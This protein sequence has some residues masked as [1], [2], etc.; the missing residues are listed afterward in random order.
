[1]KMIANLTDKLIREGQ[2]P[3]NERDIFLYGFDITLY[4]LWST[5]VLLLIGLLLGDFAGSLII[6]A[7]FY[8][9]QTF[10]GG[11]HA[12]T[13]LKCLLT[14]IVGLLVGLSFAFF[15]EQHFVL[16]TLL[17]IGALLLLLFPLV[18][19]P[20]KAYL[21]IERKRLTMHSMIV[22]ISV[23]VIVTFINVFWNGF[24]Y[25]FSAVFLLSGI[26]RIA[27]KIAYRNSYPTEDEG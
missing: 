7:A 27:G 24:L 12:R 13:H 21:E 9:F 22:T 14:M 10:G 25:A 3:E 18:L 5:A 8:T 20:N 17:V 19:H 23:G 4:T 26:S 6:V 2:I 15:K 16:W 1:M 11:Y